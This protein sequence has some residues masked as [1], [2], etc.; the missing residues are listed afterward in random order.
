MGSGR[1]V[2]GRRMVLYVAPGPGPIRVGYVT[3]RRLGSAV[4]RNRA[5]RLLK[6]ACRAH[7]QRVKEGFDIVIVARTDI[8]GARTPLVA[9]ELAELLQ[10]AG[11]LES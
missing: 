10:R 4:A 3:G 11:V 8:A 6:E 7:A 2:R 9:D 5:K 1:A